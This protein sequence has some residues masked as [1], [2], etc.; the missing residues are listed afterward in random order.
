MCYVWQSSLSTR[1]CSMLRF[2]EIWEFLM[3]CFQLHV[4]L[5]EKLTHILYVLNCIISTEDGCISNEYSYLCLLTFLCSMLYKTSAKII[6]SVLWSKSSDSPNKSIPTRLK[7]GTNWN[8]SSARECRSNYRVVF[9]I[10]SS[11][12][13]FPVWHRPCTACRGYSTVLA[14]MGDRLWAGKPSRYTM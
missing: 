6:T 3:V 8:L 2:R 4:C 7:V 13:R 14:W 11:R 10:S 9:V 12:V 5:L 1:F